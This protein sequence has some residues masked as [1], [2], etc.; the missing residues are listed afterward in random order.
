MSAGKRT[1]T[2]G[3]AGWMAAILSIMAAAA[4]LAPL[5]PPSRS[6]AV[7]AGKVSPGTAAPLAA[8]PTTLLPAAVFG[9]DDRVALPPLYRKYQDALGVLFNIRSRSVCT[10]FCVGEAVIATAGHCLFKTRGEKAPKLEEFWFARGYDDTRDYARIAGHASRAAAQNVVAGSTALSV[11]P[12]IDAT[13]DWAFVRLNRP[14]CT[15]SVFEV[16]AMA[17]DDIIA[18]SE[19]GQVFQLAYHRDFVLWKQAY[20]KPCKAAKSFEDADWP[21]VSADFS[22]PDALLLHQCDTGGASSGSPL[23]VETPRGPKVVAINVGTYVQ[24]K[25]IVRNGQTVQRMKPQTIANTAVTATAFQSALQAFRSA[26]VLMTSASMKELQGTLTKSGHYNGPLDGSY[27]I[28]LRTAIAAFEAAERLPVT[29][30]ASEALLLKA[31][32]TVTRR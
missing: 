19:A 10:A 12:P 27:G 23:L 11:S 14:V 4:L 31:R 1:G 13:S 7:A 15:K 29:G 9:A 28:A 20:S 25:V 18:A 5:T 3:H 16:E 24:S 30:I 22:K 2:G 21:T 8:A 32:E 6:Q 26:T 17:T